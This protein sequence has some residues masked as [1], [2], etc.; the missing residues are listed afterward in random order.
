[1]RTTK[2]S[3]RV[4]YRLLL[5]CLLGMVTVGTLQVAHAAPLA[6]PAYSI[7]HAGKLLAEPGKDPVTQATIVVTQGTIKEI[8]IGRAHV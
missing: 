3:A 6:P 1:M 5:G 2:L 7:V 8:Q 4:T